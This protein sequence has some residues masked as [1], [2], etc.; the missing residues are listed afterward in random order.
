M[1]AGGPGADAPETVLPSLPNFR[2]TVEG[3]QGEAGA[4]QGFTMAPSAGIEEPAAEEHPG[5]VPKQ[6]AAKRCDL[7]G[8]TAVERPTCRLCALKEHIKCALA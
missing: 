8:A 7:A 3:A 1:S 5:P 4:G 2:A 6:R